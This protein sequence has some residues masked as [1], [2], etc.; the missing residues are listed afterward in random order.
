MGK[1]LNGKLWV[2]QTRYEVHFCSQ[3]ISL[4]EAVMSDSRMTPERVAFA[5]RNA[6]WT[7]TRPLPRIV[8]PLSVSA[9]RS[10][11]GLPGPW[12]ISTLAMGI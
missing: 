9:V 3:Q 6:N 5:F 2:A 10:I 4:R 1:W 7:G 8:L 12:G 11:C